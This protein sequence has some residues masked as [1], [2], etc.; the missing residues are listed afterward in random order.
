[1]NTDIKEIDISK[2]IEEKGEKGFLIDIN[3]AYTDEIYLK[4]IPRNGI[5]IFLCKDDSGFVNV[6]NKE[7]TLQANSVVVLPENHIIEIAPIILEQNSMIAVTLDYILNMPSP[8]D[9]NIFSYSRYL[10]AI[11]V[12]D[13]KFEDLMSYYKFLYKESLENGKYKEAIINSIFYALILEIVAEYE[14]V[15]ATESTDIK[16]EELSDRFF[17]LLATYYKQYR[18]VQ[19]YAEKLN[20]TPKY[21]STAIKRITGRPLLEWIHDA[22]LMDA[23]ILLRTTNLTVQQ[24]SEQLNFSSPSAFVQFF[25]KHTGKTPKKQ[26]H[27]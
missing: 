26:S 17:R 11:K 21:L 9:T 27:F 1:M 2:I 6:D 14:K 20:L 24:I 16:A 4:F 13:E 10:S 25:K 5:I 12:T 22:V 3:Q 7:Y 8:I 18:S 15:F 23:K 19:F